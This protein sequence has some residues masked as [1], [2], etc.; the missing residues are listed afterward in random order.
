MQMQDRKFYS[1]GLMVCFIFLLFSSGFSQSKKV[2]N[3]SVYGQW[4]RLSNEK[5][6]SDGKWII[7]TI[8]NEESDDVTILHNTSNGSDTKF[9]RLSNVLMSDDGKLITAMIT[10]PKAHVKELRRKKT[11]RDDLPKDSLFVFLPNTNKQFKFP[12]VSDIKKS[13]YYSDFVAFK[14]DTPDYKKDTISMKND[15]KKQGKENGNHLLLLNTASLV[16]DTI[17]YVKDYTIAEKAPFVFAYL[18]GK[19]S[20]NSYEVIRY[21]SR[22]KSTKQ[23][24]SDKLEEI[25]FHL[26]EEGNKLV[27]IVSK[28]TT[29]NQILERSVY[30]WTEMGQNAK[31]IINTKNPVIPEGWHIPDY[32]PVNFSNSSSKIFLG[33]APKPILAD[34]SALEEEMVQ[35]EV[36]NYTDPVLYT[37][38]EVRVNQDKRK[39]YTFAYDTESDKL[40]KIASEDLD[41]VIM[42]RESNPNAILLQNRKKYGVET[43]WAG[44][45]ST[46]LYIHDIKTGKNNLIEEKLSGTPRISPDGRYATWFDS[47]KSV[48][49]VLNFEDGN[50]RILLE[51]PYISFADELNDVPDAPGSYGMVGWTKGDKE[52][53]IYDRYDIWMV[54]PMDKTKKKLTNG[55]QDKIEYRYVNL[56]PDEDYISIENTILLRLFDEKTKESGYASLNTKTNKLQLLEKG[57]FS[58]SARLMKAA[59]TNDIITKR[60]SFDVF[61]DILLTDDKFKSFK[62]ISNANPQQKDYKWGS[63]EIFKWTNAT[64]EN[65]E[66]LLVKPE[67]F[68]PKKKYPILIN[69]Y[70]RSS[71]GLHTHRAPYAHR[72]TINYTYYANKGYIL[73]N[74]DITYRIGY[75][76][77]SCYEDLMSGLE[78]LTG[79]GCID[80]TK[81]GLQ[82]HSW[83]G[84]QVAYLLNKTNKFACAES[85]APVVNMTS[86]YGGIRWESGMSRMFQYEKTQSRIGK[87]LWE[88]QDLY[89]TNSPLF[90]MTKT[91]TPV[92]ILHNDAD[93]A[94]PWYQGIEYFMALRRLGKPAWLLN[95]NGEPHWPVKWQNRYDFNVR[96]EQFFD[97]YLKGTPAPQWMKSGVPAMHKGIVTGYEELM[98]K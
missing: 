13:R 77:E 54:N 85:G 15:I 94:V 27:A 22:T 82:G 10:P 51:D 90:E 83:G 49:K 64:G 89:M 97:H 4:N 44:G 88:A 52:V 45:L 70:E 24:L 35:V 20:V 93:G 95:Y 56:D 7:Y 16:M 37:T 59:N 74:P 1:V 81:M 21:D 29:K 96:M 91:N 75:P 5:I 84:Y 55:R 67:D 43:T 86:A 42:N 8:S 33:F 73:F 6:S 14:M 36:W 23:V 48:W 18:T 34:T 2:M 32:S 28:D 76:G 11:K 69:F 17:K 31:Q 53:L 40:V 92:L 39:T 9:E 58:Y 46:D 71:D 26:N 25:K 47:D 30:Y 61:P 87:T 62:K 78:K 80:T 63:I 12:K 68:D 66:G 3:P 38:Q 72:S 98:D 50:S 79:L 65:L 19:D 60:E 57:P 41:N